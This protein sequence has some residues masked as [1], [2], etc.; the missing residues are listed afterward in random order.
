MDLNKVF[1]TIGSQMLA[2]FDGFQSQITH[3]GERGSERETSI[4]LFLEAY[5][6]K[7]YAIASG[8]IVDS[9]GNTSRQC[10]LVIFDSQ[11][12]PLLLAGKDYRIFPAESV[13]AVIEVKSVL[14]TAQ[15]KKAAD[16]IF[17]VKNLKRDNGNIAGVVFA[18]KATGEGKTIE[19]YTRRVQTINKSLQ[20]F[21]YVDLWCILDSGII[22]LWDEEGL[23]RVSD[24]PSERIMVSWHEFYGPP[25]LLW[26]F[27]QL[28][29]LLDGQKNAGPDYRS[30]SHS[31]AIGLVSISSPTGEDVEKYM[32]HKTGST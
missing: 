12:C 24:K 27:I 29:D 6:P 28:L 16:N 32:P 25:V 3:K 5:L 17:S 13:Y 14:D 23:T 31:R 10:D 4:K 22:C 30:Y 1:S 7:R 21:Q 20:P 8:E 2:D 18:Y 19:K 11:N 15:L 26:F 9:Q